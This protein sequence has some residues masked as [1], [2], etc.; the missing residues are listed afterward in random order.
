[1][2]S[3]GAVREEPSARA[4]SFAYV[5]NFAALASSAP[6]FAV[7]L[8]SRGFGGEEISSLLAALLLVN[9][10][11]TLAWTRLADRI[12]SIGAVLRIVSVGS[13]A[14]AIPA[15]FGSPPV[16]VAGLLCLAACRAPF[17]ALL[18]TLILP[19]ARRFGPVRA[20][21]T[22]GYVA[23][24]LVAGLV[25]KA[26]GAR[27]IAFATVT[28]LVL[29]ALASLFVSSA[30]LP[31]ASQPIA[32]SRSPLG[33]ALGRPRFQLLLAIALLSEV[34]LAPYDSLFP[35]YLTHL[36][37]GVFAAAALAVG[38]VAEFVFLLGLGRWTLRSRAGSLLVF[39]SACST[40]R[41]ALVWLVTSPF[42]LVATQA[43][44]CF[45]FGAFYVASITLVNDESSASERTTSQGVFRAFTFGLAPAA[46]LFV[47]GKVEHQR[48][49]REVFFVAAIAAGLATA[50]AFRMRAMTAKAQAQSVHM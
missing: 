3:T 43:L 34:G 21:G 27:G 48:G 38:A 13:V 42:A 28:L 40:L 16:V 19:T 23:G 4:L 50:L 7:Y 15:F 32:S 6:F 39:A 29:A 49:L 47:A 8:A 10:V 1:M 11:A 45:S 2:S 5:T 31:R 24:A 25:T 9:V 37:D 14:C 30:R 44:H 33:G 17:G 36:A 41:W 18:D 22:A 35:A 26:F 20:W 12:G 46:A